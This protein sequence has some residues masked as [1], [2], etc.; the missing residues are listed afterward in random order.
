MKRL[1]LLLA[2]VAPAAFA[3]TQ[4]ADYAGMLEGHNALRVALKLP[5]LRWST[6]AAQQ[7]QSWADRLAAEGCAL[8]YNPDDRRRE[9]YGENILKAWSQ[10]PYQGWRRTPADVVQR[11]QEEARYYDHATHTC[12]APAGKQCGQYLQMIWETT[13]VMGC[14]RAR[15]STSEV[16]VCNYTPRGN[17]EDLKPYGNPPPPPPAPEV[18]VGALECRIQVGAGDDLP[19]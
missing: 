3:N 15:C 10:Q 2:L 19:R 13:E 8:R 4:P 9:L 17:Q 6:T 16:W 11:W 5:P 1:L 7:A 18:A 12:R 14:G